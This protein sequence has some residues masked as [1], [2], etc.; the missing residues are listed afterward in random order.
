MLGCCLVGC[1]NPVAHH[2]HSE[3]GLAVEH[4]LEWNA[5]ATD[6][7][8]IL[9]CNIADRYYRVMAT[10]PSTESS[11]RPDAAHS[12]LAFRSVAQV[13]LWVVLCL[14]MRPITNKDCQDW[15]MF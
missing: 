7:C 9:V 1:F 14:W 12:A 11:N 15:S 3:V 8:C 10:A 4:I 6:L 13:W 5:S 2:R